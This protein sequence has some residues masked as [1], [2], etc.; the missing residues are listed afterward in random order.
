[1]LRKMKR[2]NVLVV[3]GLL[4]LLFLLRQAGNVQAEAPFQ[5]YIPIAMPPT[6]VAETPP[7][8]TVLHVAPSGSTAAACGTPASPCRNL[9]LA[10]NNAKAAATVNVIIKVAQG[11][12]T[13][14]G[15]AVAD[16]S[17]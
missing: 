1:M 10:V 12:Y 15:W 4:S 11:T 17:F 9:Q 7:D 3:A 5:L 2:L 14:S 13:G 8:T 6:Q 16:I